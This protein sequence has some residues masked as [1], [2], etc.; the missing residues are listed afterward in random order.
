MK[1]LLVGVFFLIA[2]HATAQT[3]ADEALMRWERGINTTRTERLL[4]LA[5]VVMPDC[6]IA[7]SKED[8]TE[9]YVYW[10]FVV[11]ERID[12]LNASGHPLVDPNEEKHHLQKPLELTIVRQYQLPDL[13][14]VGPEM[15]NAN[16]SVVHQIEIWKALHCVVEK[17]GASKFFSENGSSRMGMDWPWDPILSVFGYDLVPVDA[18]KTKAYLLPN[19]EDIEPLDA[20]G[21]F[22]R[23]AEAKGALTFPSEATEKYFFERYESNYFYNMTN[24]SKARAWFHTAPWKPDAPHLERPTRPVRPHP[25]Q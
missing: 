10:R 8:V 18:E 19:M 24:V 20:L 23:G 3:P 22:F 5:P 17:Y 21:R 15:P 11:Q 14:H 2:Q 9:F 4:A 12:E 13:V 25:G 16:E 1:R 7:A 6:D